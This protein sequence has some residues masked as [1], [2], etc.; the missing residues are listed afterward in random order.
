MRGVQEADAAA[1]LAVRVL[2][3]RV[4][5]TDLEQGAATLDALG[6]ASCQPEGKPPCWHHPYADLNDPFTTEDALEWSK[7]REQRMTDCAEGRGPDWS[8]FADEYDDRRLDLP[9]RER[10]AREGRERQ[11][12]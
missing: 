7:G 12:F 8:G 11:G 6:W 9:E 5:T 2:W 1:R 4:V 10:R 3:G